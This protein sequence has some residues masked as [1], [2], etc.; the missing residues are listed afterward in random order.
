MAKRKLF[1][2]TI[3]VF[4]D[5]HQ[6]AWEDMPQQGWQGHQFALSSEL[7]QARIIL[8][9]PSQGRSLCISPTAQTPKSTKTATLIT[10]PREQPGL[11]L[12]RH[13]F[14]YLVPFPAYTPTQHYYSETCK[15]TNVGFPQTHPFLQNW[16]DPSQTQ[17]TVF[18]EY[19]ED[20]ARVQR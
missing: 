17:R 7:G 19:R 13:I 11:W 14:S 18:P 20:F 4:H 5:S 12:D 2:Q 15:L 6:G 3:C 8:T 10:P 16:E 9:T 1:E